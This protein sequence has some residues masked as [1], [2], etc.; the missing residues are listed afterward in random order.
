MIVINY[1]IYFS[2]QRSIIANLN[3]NSNHQFISYSFNYTI[4][5]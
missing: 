5:L 1:A 2:S 4:I 3:N